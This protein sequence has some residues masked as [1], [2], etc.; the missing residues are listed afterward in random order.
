MI[1]CVAVF[2][3]ALNFR[4]DAAPIGSLLLIISFFLGVTGVFL[5]GVQV[6]T[7]L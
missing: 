7:L 2:R 5:C 3:Y 4:V 6:G 1:G